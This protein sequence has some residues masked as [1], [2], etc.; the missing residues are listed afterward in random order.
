MPWVVSCKD[1]SLLRH[2]HHEK[3]GLSSLLLFDFQLIQSTSF[4]HFS[5]QIGTVLTSVGCVLDLVQTHYM[6][7]DG[8]FLKSHSGVFPFATTLGIGSGQT[9][10]IL[11]FLAK[12]RVRS[13]HLWLLSLGAK[14][15]L[16]RSAPRTPS[17][18]GK[19]QLHFKNLK[20]NLF[21]SLQTFPPC[22]I[23]PRLSSMQLS[24][25]QMTAT[26]PQLSLE[27]GGLMSKP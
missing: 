17:F 18:V 7:E 13:S 8:Q 2:I 3:P 4:Y 21:P 10:A 1:F 6:M 26:L 9:K 5:K 20:H 25:P 11:V 15:W 23:T 27:D 22:P 24:L 16:D 19:L 12:D 14:L